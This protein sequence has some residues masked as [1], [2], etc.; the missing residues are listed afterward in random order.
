MKA[1]FAALLLLGSLTAAHA[2]PA[3]DLLRQGDA[4]AAKDQMA[5]ALAMYLRAGALQ[6]ERAEIHLSLAIAYGR[7]ALQKP[8]LERLEF[9]RL[10]QREAQR[11]VELDPRS[12]LAWQ[13]LG[14]WN[15][16]MAG[17]GGPA[18]FFA[19]TFGQLPEA[20]YEKALACFQKAAALQPRRLAPQAELGRT[21]A[22]LGRKDEARAALEK[23]LA[24]PAREKDDE[25]TKTRARQA[26]QA[27][28]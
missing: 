8:P 10:I 14:R 17:L 21:L 22:A 11:A 2:D 6:P 3:A 19:Q 25:E 5:E 26:R 28:D 4:L 12:D 1:P 27:L 7:L 16:E 9:A 18:R 24:M 23:A 15:F 13:V 20:S